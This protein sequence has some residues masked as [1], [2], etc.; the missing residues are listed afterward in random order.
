V[1]LEFQGPDDCPGSD[2]IVF[3]SLVEG[4]VARIA[5]PYDQ[6]FI[7]GFDGEGTGA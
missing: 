5:E 1:R 3:R 4:E 7:L 6:R 2:D